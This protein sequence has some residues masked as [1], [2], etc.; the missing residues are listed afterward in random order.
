MTDISIATAMNGS[1]SSTS[2][3][4]HNP[5]VLM[6]GLNVLES[7]DLAFEVATTLKGITARLGIPYVFKASFD[8]ANRSS[9]HSFRGPGMEKGLQ[10]LADIK[11]ELSLPIVTD[12]H[13]PYQAAPVAEV[14]DILQIPAFLCRQTDLIAAACQ[15]NT[16]I[17]IKKM[18]MMAPHEVGNI[19]K[20]MNELEFRDILL[21]ERGTLFGYN[22]LIVDPLAFPQLKSFG[23]PVVFDVT[24][25]LQQPGGLGDKTAG[26]GQYVYDLA[27]VGMV[28]GIAGL[29]LETHPDPAKAKCD[30][31]CAIALA[32]VEGFLTKVKAL[33]DFVKTQLDG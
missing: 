12:I 1:V 24:H 14:A 13:E 19:I 29:F 4:N 26:R 8:K 23:L 15:Q 5:F 30:G 16:P 28:S 18:Q 2:L 7:R 31:P 25:A 32:E 22:N 9:I 10:I 3:T 6:A 33:D 27:K 11:S 20:K 17:Q 21:C